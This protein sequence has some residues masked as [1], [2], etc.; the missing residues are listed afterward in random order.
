MP[1]DVKNSSPQKSVYPTVSRGPLSSPNSN[2]LNHPRPKGKNRNL[3]LW[4]WILFAVLFVLAALWLLGGSNIL[5][6]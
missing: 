5:E 2:Y 3:H 1:D 6:Y 4:I